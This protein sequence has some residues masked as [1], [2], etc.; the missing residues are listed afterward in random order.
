MV[1]FL[2][3][4]LCRCDYTAL[5]LYFL[6]K[7]NIL[8]FAA[9]HLTGFSMALV[10]DPDWLSVL[11]NLTSL[12]FSFSITSVL[13]SENGGVDELGFS[14]FFTTGCGTP[15]SGAFSCCTHLHKYVHTSWLRYLAGYLICLW[16]QSWIFSHFPLGILFCRE[17]RCR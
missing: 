7:L 13:C 1:K 8:T 17:A 16:K 6:L 9:V 14:S 11:N 4:L 2:N 3:R 5:K 12:F 15:T 10:F